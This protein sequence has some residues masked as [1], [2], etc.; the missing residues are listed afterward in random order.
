MGEFTRHLQT[1]LAIIGSVLA[2]LAFEAGV[3][4]KKVEGVV[5]YVDKRHED[6]KDSI[7]EL[8]AM[9]IETQRMV[10]ELY[11]KGKK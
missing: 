3:M 5:L 7:T 9:Q 10:F 8:K 11:T 1:M 4:D 6:V 2:A